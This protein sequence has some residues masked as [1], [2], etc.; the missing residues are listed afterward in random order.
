M[1]LPHSQ[2]SYDVAVV[3]GGPAGAVTALTLAKEG[4]RVLSWRRIPL[5][6]HKTCGGGV[7]GRAI[8]SLPGR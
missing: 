1:V 2:N 3:G 5:P 8:R 7:A 4:V 6:R